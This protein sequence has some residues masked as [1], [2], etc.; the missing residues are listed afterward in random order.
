MILVTGATG[1]AG[2]AVIREFARQHAPVRALVR[3]RAKARSF[4]TLPIV[5][6]VEGDMRRPETLAD[7]FSGVDRV[8]S[9][10][11]LTRRW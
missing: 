2:S 3:N 4:E 11:P 10:P 1:L 9:S 6:L 8:C 5:Q 7:A